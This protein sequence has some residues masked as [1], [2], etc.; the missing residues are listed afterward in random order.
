MKHTLIFINLKNILNGWRLQ[1]IFSFLIIFKAHGI[2]IGRRK[3]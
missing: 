1:V 2:V 3:N